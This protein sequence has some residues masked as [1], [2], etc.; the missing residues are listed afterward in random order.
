MEDYLE[1][2]GAKIACRLFVGTGKF[3]G[4]SADAG[5]FAGRRGRCHDR[6]PAD[7]STAARRRKISWIIS[8][9]LAP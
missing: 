4:Q 3:A 7:G 8:R 1:I 2:G 6:R 9:R 5:C